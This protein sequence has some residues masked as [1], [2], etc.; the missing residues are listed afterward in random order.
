[1]NN[2]SNTIIQ[3]R[4]YPREHAAHSHRFYQWVLPIQG[5]LELEISKNAGY[6]THDHA[7]FIYPGE[8]HCFA[9]H[10][11]NEF[12][13]LDAGI[14]HSWMSSIDIPAFWNLTPALQNYL[15]F[16]KTYLA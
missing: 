8:P 10:C 11:E 3:L 2:L 14:D 7:A 5:I 15:Q 4:K 16:A 9:S 1:M 6:V 12:L 13:V